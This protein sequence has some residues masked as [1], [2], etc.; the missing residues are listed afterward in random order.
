MSTS[1]KLQRCATCGKTQYPPRELC[2]SCLADNLEWTIASAT[3]TILAITQLHHTYDP[4]FH[5]QR[6]ITVAQVH[7]DYGPTVICF[8]AATCAAG[9]RVHIM[10]D[11]DAA[12][13]TVLTA[14][15]QPLAAVAAP[16][17]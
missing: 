9:E 6:P 7:V 3:G 8:L 12:G 13:R 5:T 17:R 2:S 4:S 1:L 11:T 16:P 15:T 14:A 10:A